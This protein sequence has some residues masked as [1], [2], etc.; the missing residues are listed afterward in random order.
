MPYP[1]IL[2]KQP[3]KPTWREAASLIIL[4]QDDNSTNDFDYN[5]L[6]IKRSRG[7]SF[8][9]SAFVFPGGA[10]EL[11]DFDVAWYNQYEKCGFTKQD[12][13]K[14]SDDVIGPRPPIVSD[15]TT[16]SKAEKDQANLS[17][18]HNDIGL[19]ISAIRETFEEAG[20]FRETVNFV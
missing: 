2:G 15:S 20:K 11:S 10:L 7:S 9:A 3:D 8:M 16:L 13:K 12:L 6:M 4:V 1:S 5:I 17:F 18:I 19:R 14:I